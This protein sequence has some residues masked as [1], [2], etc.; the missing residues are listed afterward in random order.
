MKHFIFVCSHTL[1]LSVTIFALLC[2][3]V[4]VHHT[5]AFLPLCIYVCSAPWNAKIF[6]GIIAQ[7]KAPSLYAAPSPPC[8]PS[9][10]QIQIFFIGT[11]GTRHL[12]HLISTVFP[13]PVSQHQPPQTHYISFISTLRANLTNVVIIFYL[14][15]CSSS[16]PLCVHTYLLPFKFS[17]FCL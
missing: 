13:L 14:P 17:L 5:C 16:S 2:A 7:K 15:F 11:M 12:L 10:F 4:H 1:P 9:C 6:Y 3:Y 8:F